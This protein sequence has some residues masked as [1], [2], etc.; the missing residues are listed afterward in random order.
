MIDQNSQVKN[1]PAPLT[2]AG[3]AV[4]YALERLFLLAIDVAVANFLLACMH[5][6][7]DWRLVK[8]PI[9]PASQAYDDGAM[10]F[11]LV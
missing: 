2:T 1:F 11:H 7:L 10:V 5:Q 4:G 3:S 8:E 9:A 6:L